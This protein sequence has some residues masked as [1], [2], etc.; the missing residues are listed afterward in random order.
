MTPSAERTAHRG[1]SPVRCIG[2]MD[3]GLLM[4]EGLV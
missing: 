1:L 3:R 2:I 4:D